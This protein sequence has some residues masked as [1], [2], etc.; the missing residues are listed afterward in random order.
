M[1][2][3]TTPD[4]A[5]CT[6]TRAGTV[7]GVVDPTPGS[8]A[9]GPSGKDL[10]VT[11]RKPGQQPASGAVKA[12]YRGVGFGQLVTGGFAAV[13]EGAVKSTDFRYDPAGASVTLPPG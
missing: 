5:A 8:L 6:V 11:C 2:I 3:R 7:L 13:V 12:V 1:A 9:V 10:L 4:G